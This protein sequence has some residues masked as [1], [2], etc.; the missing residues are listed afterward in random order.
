MDKTSFISTTVLPRKLFINSHIISS[1]RSHAIGPMHVK[2][3]PTNKCTRACPFCSFKNRDKA[4][5]IDYRHLVEMTDQL[6]S[7]GLRAV[8]LTGGGEPLAYRHIAQY[9]CFLNERGIETGLVTNGDLLKN[10]PTY[11]I[12]MLTWCR[13]SLGDGFSYKDINLD[14]V[15]L[16]KIDW[17]FSYFVSA[18][19]D[20]QNIVDSLAFA[21][22]HGF[23]HVRFADDAID[24]ASNLDGLRAAIEGRGANRDLAVYQ[25]TKNFC[26]GNPSCLSSLIKP[27]I[28]PDGNLY[29]CCGI[30]YA[31]DPV[32][33]D[34]PEAFSMGKD[35]R[36]I[37]DNQRYFDG[38]ACA[39]CLQKEHN[40]FLN[41]L[42]TAGT[43]KHGRFI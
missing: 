21:G 13:I 12:E 42:W 22:K 39:R 1:V 37:Y 19:P 25:T 34:W 26:R 11:I 29:P 24:P 17:S 35:V 3:C 41:I 38:S 28:G 5:E 23:T 4:L 31:T 20:I 33:M 30:S 16:A 7:Y 27:V 10:F 8:T 36:D 43:V 2:V 32:S 14:I 40:D 15:E 6:I 18:V 9:I